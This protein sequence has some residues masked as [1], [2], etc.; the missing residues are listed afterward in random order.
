M[1]GGRRG[2]CL[3][4]VRNPCG[5]ART[6]A[7]NPARLAFQAFATW[8][9]RFQYRPQM[10]DARLS[11]ILKGTLEGLWYTARHGTAKR[12]HTHSNSTWTRSYSSLSPLTDSMAEPSFITRKNTPTEIQPAP[13]GSPCHR[14]N[15]GFSRFTLLALSIVRGIS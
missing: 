3:P 5:T 8:P 15:V 6:P 14:C 9:V 13:Q 11:R 10:P 2:S 4:T 12:T 7:K 1:K